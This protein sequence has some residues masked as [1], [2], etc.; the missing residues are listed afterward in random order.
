MIHSF[1]FNQTKAPQFYQSLQL[2]LF[3]EKKKIAMQNQSLLQNLFQTNCTQFFSF[4]T[5]LIPL[6]SYYSVFKFPCSHLCS[7]LLEIHGQSCLFHTPGC[8][9]STTQ[10]RTFF[11][12]CQGH[13]YSTIITHLLLPFTP[14][15]FFF[16]C[17]IDFSLS[18]ESVTLAFKYV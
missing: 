1:A 6:Q 15:S 12:T 9:N 14:F 4:D 17:I 5:I 7:G 10:P 2:I 13:S 18:T 16:S 8:L 3:T 11:H